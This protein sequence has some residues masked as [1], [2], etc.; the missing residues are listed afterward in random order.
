ML[1]SFVG[2]TQYPIKTIF[3]GDS[4]IILTIE[5]SDKINQ[6]I[7]KNS[8]SV[9]ELTKKNKEN[10]EELRRLNKLLV[11]QNCVIDSLYNLLLEYR[12]KEN[13]QNAL[14]DSV[15]IWSLGPSL[16]YTEYPDD[17][18]VYIM[19]LSQYYMTTDDFGI[20]MVKMSDREYKEYQE[21]IKTYG[22]SE[23]AFWEFRSKM[24]IKPYIIEEEDKKRVWKFRR[25]WDKY[26][27]TEE[28]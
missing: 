24:R 8:K 3:K 9:K 4:V 17:S 25:D 27:K 23:R 1:M 10:E 14:V 22:M 21:F 11:E 7:E 6:L 2:Y 15:W 12:K 20:V 16:I 26:K 13:A 19:D 18:T 5:Q 28:K